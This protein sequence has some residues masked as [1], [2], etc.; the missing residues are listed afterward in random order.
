V[1]RLWR[2]RKF[3]QLLW[4]PLRTVGV[5][6]CV[7]YLPYFHPLAVNGEQRSLDLAA[8]SSRPPTHMASPSAV[9]DPQ[10]RPHQGYTGFPRHPPVVPFPMKIRVDRRETASMKS[11]KVTTNS[12][13]TSTTVPVLRYWVYGKPFTQN[14]LMP[15]DGARSSSPR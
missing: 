12:R 10:V 15:N 4:Q 13:R 7:R 1:P 14:R 11:L 6:V 2:Q 9:L 3:N 8:L 5:C